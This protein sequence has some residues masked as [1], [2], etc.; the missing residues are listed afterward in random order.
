MAN[1]TAAS[2]CTR[3]PGSFVS[4]LDVRVP[5]RTVPPGFIEVYQRG[6]IPGKNFGFLDD[7]LVRNFRDDP[8]FADPLRRIRRLQLHLGERSSF[9]LQISNEP[10]TPNASSATL[11][12]ATEL[13]AT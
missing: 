6:I 4:V 8:A 10:A 12:N 5:G 2:A 3:K 9:P 1:S 7:M 11:P 13:H